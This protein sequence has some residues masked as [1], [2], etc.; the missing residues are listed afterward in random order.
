MLSVLIKKNNMEKLPGKEI[1]LI[2]KEVNTLFAHT[3]LHQATNLK[4]VLIAFGIY[5]KWVR[6]NCVRNQWTI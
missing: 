2:H 1:F 5:T 4:N 3:C 6:Q